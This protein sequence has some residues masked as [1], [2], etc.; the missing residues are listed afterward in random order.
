M[1]AK[2]NARLI[3]ASFALLA[4][5]ADRLVEKFCTELVHR[6]SQVKPL[7]AAADPLVQRKKLIA[8][9]AAPKSVAAGKVAAAR[10]VAGGS[11]GS[12]AEWK[13]F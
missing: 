3:E 5:H 1:A 7:F 11:T 12:G 6:H 10:K 13:E 2:L 4:P 9:A 8:A